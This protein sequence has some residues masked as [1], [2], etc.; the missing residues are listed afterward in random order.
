MI[1]RQ[2][3]QAAAGLEDPSR[4]AQRLGRGVMGAIA[5]YALHPSPDERH[6]T[7]GAPGIHDR[8]DFD[9]IAQA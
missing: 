3:H 2:G 4:L 7:Y 9:R 1:H 6:F 5:K 8:L